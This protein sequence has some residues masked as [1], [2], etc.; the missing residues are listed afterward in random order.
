MSNKDRIRRRGLTYKART[1]TNAPR[2]K[3]IYDPCD[4]FSA[5]SSFTRIELDEMLND[6]Y[7]AIGTRFRRGECEYE[8]GC[9]KWGSLKLRKI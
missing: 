9:Y 1:W 8:V 2:Y 7:L 4:S 5:A 6:E 3:V